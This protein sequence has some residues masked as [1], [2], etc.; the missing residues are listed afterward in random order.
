MRLNDWDGRYSKDTKDWAKSVTLP[1]VR[2]KRLFLPTAHP[3]VVNGYIRLM[4]KEL[5]RSDKK[6][7]ILNALKQGADKIKQ[8]DPHKEMQ[9]KNKKGIEV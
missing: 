3:A 8:N 1:Q 7:S 9:Q 2:D 5:G 4:R 6:P